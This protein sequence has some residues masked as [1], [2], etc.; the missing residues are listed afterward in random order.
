MSVWTTAFLALSLMIGGCGSDDG[1]DDEVLDPDDPGEENPVLSRTIEVWVTGE[2]S[3]W[4][5]EDWETEWE[6]GDDVCMSVTVELDGP[7][8]N[9]YQHFEFRPMTVVPRQA[10][11]PA[12]A[13][14]GGFA[15]EAVFETFRAADGDRLEGLWSVIPNLVRCDSEETWWAYT[16]E[17]GLIDYFEFTYVEN[18]LPPQH[19]PEYFGDIVVR[20][21][22]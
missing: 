16:A 9:A 13:V 8:D 14:F 18:S 15:F 5:F 17:E 10:N 7:H 12:P 20:R 1:H 22:F 6:T 19:N 3:Q 2:G 4:E 11:G 21:S